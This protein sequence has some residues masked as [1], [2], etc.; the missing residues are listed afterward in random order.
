MCFLTSFVNIHFKINR[1]IISHC[2]ICY[3]LCLIKSIILQAIRVKIFMEP[4][5]SM[6]TEATEVR[7]L[8]QL[9]FIPSLIHRTMEAISTDRLTTCSKSPICDLSWCIESWMVKLNIVTLQKCTYL[10]LWRYMRPEKK[11]PQK[12]NAVILV[13]QDDYVCKA[14]K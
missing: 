14:R 11:L 3:L 6:V 13:R 8:S 10:H 5:W 12:T 1:S 9:L 4:R 7:C 2:V